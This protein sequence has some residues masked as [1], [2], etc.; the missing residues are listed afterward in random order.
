MTDDSRHDDIHD[1]P[2]VEDLEPGVR[3]S[4]AGVGEYGP[5]G[6]A[7]TPVHL[8]IGAVLVLVGLVG[9]ALYAFMPLSTPVEGDAQA[10]SALQSVIIIGAAACFGVGLLLIVRGIVL[11]RRGHRT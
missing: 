6:K 1:R 9:I 8:I 2:Q 10:D 7:K 11:R 3:D 5:G 4:G